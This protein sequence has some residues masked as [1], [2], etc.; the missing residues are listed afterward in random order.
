MGQ[1][2]LL[3]HL[4]SKIVALVNAGVYVH[5]CMPGTKETGSRNIDLQRT[6]LIEEKQGKQWE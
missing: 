3:E 5:P 2:D 6:F 4:A 1:S